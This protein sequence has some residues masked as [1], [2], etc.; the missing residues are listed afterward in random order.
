[1]ANLITI[2]DYAAEW[3]IKDYHVEPRTQAGYLY[4]EEVVAFLA[5]L[6]IDG[7]ELTHGYWADYDIKR[8]KQLADGA[9]AR[10]FS[11]VGVADLAVPPSELQKSVELAFMLLDRAAALGARAIFLLPEMYKQNLPL[12]SQRAWLIEGLARVAERARAMKLTILCENIDYPPMRPLM[13]RGRQ[14]RDLCAAVDS[15]AFRLIYDVAAPLFVGED[16]LQT[17]EQMGPYVGHVHVKNFRQ[18]APGEEADRC[19]ESNDGRRYTGTT[20]D[21]GVI[22][23]ADIVKAL[24]KRYY[25]ST[26]QIEYQGVDDPRVALKH[27]VKYFR[28]LLV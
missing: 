14:C 12:E 21:A 28:S 4:R 2:S 18:L 19:L 15:P 24:R 20:L 6:E 9:G 22:S 3:A 5:T 10:V 8:L 27:N 23:I 1:M 17:L 25:D 13:G 7:I 16:A 11:Y 26:I